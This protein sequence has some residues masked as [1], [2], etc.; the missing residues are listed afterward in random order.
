MKQYF[1]TP[2]ALDNETKS[3]Q[4]GLPSDWIRATYIVNRR[5]NERIKALAYWQRLTV[6]EVVN[7]AFT[8]YLDGKM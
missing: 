1:L 8:E 6:K 4:K 7:E 5:V 3:T 2:K